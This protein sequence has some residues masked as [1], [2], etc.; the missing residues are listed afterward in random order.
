MTLAV[1]GADV[2][3]NGAIAAALAVAQVVAFVDEHEPE[4]PQV[5]QLASAPG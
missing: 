5:G 4:A 1:V 3:G 2:L